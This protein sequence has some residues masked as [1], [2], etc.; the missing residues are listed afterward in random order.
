[1]IL[2]LIVAGIGLVCFSA[3]NQPRPHGGHQAALERG[4]KVYEKICIACHQPDGGGVPRMNPPLIQ[5]K[6]VLGDRKAL[7]QIVL[8]GLQG[9][10]LE[11]NGE[12]YENPMPPHA[13]LLTDQEIADVLTFVR[14]SFGNKASAVSESEVRA[15]RRRL[16]R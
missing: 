11:V 14:N 6:Y 16:S 4:K 10:Q 3:F 5:T 1:M 7:I 8:K 13:D 2:R 15:E 12:Y 9:G